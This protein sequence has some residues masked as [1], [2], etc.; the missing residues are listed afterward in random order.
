MVKKIGEATW[1]GPL[2]GGEGVLSLGDGS[3]TAKQRFTLSY[4][5]GQG[6]NPEEMLGAAQ[7]GCFSMVLSMELSNAGYK[8]EE[9]N[10]KAVITVDQGEA[11]YGI[12]DIKLVTHAKVQDI[13]IEAFSKFADKA[14]GICLITKAL[15]SVE[16][17]LEANLA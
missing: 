17:Q 9:I 5:Q 7:A 12:T 11:G 3:S 4:E 13:D 8:V 10:T 15:S 2:V 16:T 14:K 6:T 1:K